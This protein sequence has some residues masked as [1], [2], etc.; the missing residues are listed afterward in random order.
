MIIEILIPYE[1]WQ[2]GNLVDAEIN[3][4]NALIAL[5]VARKHESQERIDPIPQKE[6][7]QEP[8]KIEVNNFYGAPVNSKKPKINRTLK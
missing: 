1:Q 4:A 8:Q 5:Q 6:K 3:Y 2:P 7:Q